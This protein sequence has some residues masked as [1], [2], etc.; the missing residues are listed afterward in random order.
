MD[1]HRLSALS[2]IA[3]LLATTPNPGNCQTQPP[4]CSPMP[5]SYRKTMDLTTIRATS[6]QSPIPSRIYADD[7][8]AGET[9]ERGFCQ[10]IIH[11]CSTANWIEADPLEPSYC[12]ELQHCQLSQATIMIVRGCK[13]D[14]ALEGTRGSHIPWRALLQSFLLGDLADWFQ[15]GTLAEATELRSSAR[16]AAN[17]WD[18]A[19]AAEFGRDFAVLAEAAGASSMARTAEAFQL[20]VAFRAVGLEPATGDAPLLAYFP[21][22]DT[23]GP[24][25]LGWGVLALLDPALP[26][27]P[28]GRSVLLTDAALETI[29]T[30]AERSP[31]VVHPA[32]VESMPSYLFPD[33]Q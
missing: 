9:D 30:V 26:D 2:T 18:Y 25:E 20:D 1:L 23:V 4:H 17:A 24:T 13:Y 33:Q 7:Q 12:P 11:P 29:A 21:E 14:D 16:D 19:S 27:Q 5:I 10:L 31:A 22:T 6:P 3:V 15:N 32:L 8:V 28:S